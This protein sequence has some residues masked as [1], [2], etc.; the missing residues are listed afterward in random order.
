MLNETLMGT[1]I[2]WFRRDL[3]LRDNT[4]LLAA[5]ASGSPILPVYVLDEP[6]LG[7]G[8][9]WWLHQSLAR[10]DESLRKHG[11]PLYLLSGSAG[12]ALSQLARRTGATSLY[13]TKR[14]EPRSRCQ[15]Q[16]LQTRLAGELQ[17][18]ACDD[19]SM[20]DHNDVLTQSDR[21]FRIFTPYWKKATASPEP[22]QPQPAPRALAVARHELGSL[23]LDDL[24]LPSDSSVSYANLH[25]T[26][27]PG[28]AGASQSLDRLESVLVD[29][30]SHRDR[31]DLDATSRLSPHLHFGEVSARQVWHAANDYR[32]QPESLP[33]VAAFLRQLYWRDFSSYLL[34]HFPDIAKKPLRPEFS[35]FPWSEN[36]SGLSDWKHGRTG[37][38]IVDAGMR[39]LVSTGWM[40]N[41]VRMIVASFL[42]KD[43][44]LPWQEGAAWFNETLVDADLANNSAS[45][46]WVAGCGTDAAPFF[47]IFNPVLQGTK[48]DP[49]GYYVRRWLPELAVVANENIHQPW[50]DRAFMSGSIDYPEP[51]VDHAVARQE[52]LTRHRQMRELF[53]LVEYGQS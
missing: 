16:D 12:T 36:S 50:R 19:S 20:T 28:E 27:L 42:V 37:F 8:S 49:Q 4:A 29:Y 11:V 31:P 7:A 21:P 15:E 1:A 2:Y 32:T 40:H 25:D 53:S 52:A 24:E 3:R 18:F 33:G 14:Y 26:W 6:D 45:W 46:Q 13:Y 51:V 38:P 43:L 48:F 39:Q 22:A 10:L 44:T 17:I 30:S 23:R 34:F 35:Y 9:R 41:R 47:R 5:A